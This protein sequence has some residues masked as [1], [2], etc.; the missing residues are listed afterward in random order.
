[1][2]A[3]LRKEANNNFLKYFF[4]LINNSVFGKVIEN[5][6]KHKTQVYTTC[7]NRKKNKLFSV[8]IKLS[9]Y[10]VLTENLL[11]IEFKKE[12]KTK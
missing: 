2:N 10:K 5:V 12:I 8:R 3:E 6:Q 4:K 11:A 9:Y 1:M 7:N